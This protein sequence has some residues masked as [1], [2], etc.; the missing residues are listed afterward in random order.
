M[1]IVV[2]GAGSLGSLL[3]GFLSNVHDVTLIARESHANAVEE[4]G[5]EITGIVDEVVYP[6]SRT[7]VD[8][9]T[10]DLALVTVKAYDTSDAAACLEKGEFDAVCSLQNGL[11]N[12][13][14]LATVLDCPVLGGTVTYGADLERPGLVCMT[15]RG[16]ITLGLYRGGNRVLLERVAS[17]FSDASLEVTTTDDIRRVLW[18][19]L[20]VNAAINPLTALAHCQNGAVAHPPLRGLAAAV[21]D[22]VVQVANHNDID[23]DPTEMRSSVLEVAD[24]TADNRSSMLQDFEAG[25]RTEIDAITGAVIDRADTVDVVINETLAALVMGWERENGLRP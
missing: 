12:E 20:V 6:A 5:L 19:K 1:E 4:T 13:G 11:G 23:I 7:T 22:E 24:N 18:E 2:F 25:R 3:G 10:A 16:E 21:T 8:G 9:L 15:G 17:A 14:I